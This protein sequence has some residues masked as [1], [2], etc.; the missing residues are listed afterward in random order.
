M[1]FH[2]GHAQRA[3]PAPGPEGTRVGRAEE[4]EKTGKSGQPRASAGPPREGTEGGT[5]P[6][7]QDACL[8]RPGPKGA[9]SRA[10][11]P[12]GTTGPKPFLASRTAPPP[13]KPLCTCC[14]NAV[15]EE[16]VSV[17]VTTVTKTPTRTG[18]P[19][20]PSWLAA[21]ERG[22]NVGRALRSVPLLLSS[23]SG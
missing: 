8:A 19:W 2:H 22:R 4:G 15:A 20:L 23:V 1:G 21:R 9:T 18:N 16:S 7:P 12:T 14:K 6:R 11:A 17:V 3:V 5:H 10:A 13:T